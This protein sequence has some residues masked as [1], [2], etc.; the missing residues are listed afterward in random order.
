MSIKF[1]NSLVRFIRGEQKKEDINYH[2]RIR[3][4]I[5]EPIGKKRILSEY[6]DLSINSTEIKLAKTTPGQNGCASDFYKIF[7]EERTQIYAKF[8]KPESTLP[9]SF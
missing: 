9:G 1:I 8:Q 2:R 3:D 6:N 7:K 5:K 4:I